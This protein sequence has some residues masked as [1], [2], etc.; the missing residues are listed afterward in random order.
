MV[1]LDLDLEAPGLHYKLLPQLKE[2]DLGPQDLV[3]FLDAFVT[4]GQV[5]DNIQDYLVP[6]PAGEGQG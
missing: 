4:Q 2:G 3:D 5:P 1:A 6:V